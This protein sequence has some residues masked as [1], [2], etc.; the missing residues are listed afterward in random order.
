MMPWRFAICTL[1]NGNLNLLT[2]LS[3]RAGLPW[4]CILSA[5]VFRAYKPDPR[6]YGGVAKTFDVPPEQVML[7]AAHHDDLEGAR[8]CGLQTA[9][10]ERPLELGA[11]NPKDVSPRAVNHLHACD[12]LDLA[13]Q[14][15]C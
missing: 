2:R 7:V 8:A 10:I 14:L 4:D 9:Y 6:T 12:L 5:E 1:A 3:K 15:G 13:Q 11:R